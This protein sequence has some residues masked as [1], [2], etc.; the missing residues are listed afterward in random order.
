MKIKSSLIA[1]IILSLFISCNDNDSNEVEKKFNTSL[2]QVPENMIN[3]SDRLMF[4]AQAQAMNDVYEVVMKSMEYGLDETMYI[5][6]VSN[7]N[8]PLFKSIMSKSKVNSENNSTNFELNIDGLEVYWPYANNWDHVSAPVVACYVSDSSYI[9]GDKLKAYKLIKLDDGTFQRDSILVNEAYAKEK[10]VWIVKK[11][12]FT[13]ED[14]T[15]IFEGKAT[16]MGIKYAPRKNVKFNIQGAHMKVGAVTQATQV[17]E[18]KITSL[19][20]TTQHDTWANGGSEFRVFWFFPTSQFGLSV[21]KIDLVSLTRDEINKGTV[22]SLDF[23]AN[24]DW[25]EG[26]LHNRLKV[27]E[28][29]PGADITF[30][31]KLSTTY[32]P[33]DQEVSYTGEFKTTIDL[34]NVDD[35]IM[36]ETIARTAMF[37]TETQVD[38]TTYKKSFFK[39]GVTIGTTCRKIE[40]A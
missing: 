32:K 19:Q 20:C 14:L 1:I 3:L 5:D 24:Y 7:N 9:E 28:Y 22:R 25:F 39:A 31:I 6:D 40:G 27:V 29:D 15:N 21:H 38:N 37:T 12:S 8:K 23:T 18:T 30:E 2:Q 16:S 17:V 33:K 36:D 10:P 4:V 13:A 11:A 34:N 26:Q 35:E